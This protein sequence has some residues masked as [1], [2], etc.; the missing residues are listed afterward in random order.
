MKQLEINIKG[1]AET[2]VTND[3]LAVNVGSGS[4]A[5]FATP[6]MT[7]IME[8]ASCNCIANYLDADE[9]TVGTELNIQH[10]SATPN[11]MNITAEAVL[12]AV[13]GRMLEFKVTAYDECG[14]IGLGIH[15]R[16]V[17]KIERFT[18]KTYQKLN[19]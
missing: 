3:K 6:A 2:T 19:K 15:K 8:K 10:I 18:E 9:T 17:V 1:T 13:N 7:T 14:K 4:L 16:A 12:T 5:V 11:G